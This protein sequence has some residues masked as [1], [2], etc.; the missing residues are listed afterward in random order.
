MTI[1]YRVEPNLECSLIFY[2]QTEAQKTG[3]WSI[4][5]SRRQRPIRLAFYP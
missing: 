5:R 4:G 1:G 3:F 2:K